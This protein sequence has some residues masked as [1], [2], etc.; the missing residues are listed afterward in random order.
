MPPAGRAA[1]AVTDDAWFHFRP[2][3]QVT[4]WDEV[5]FWRPM[6]SQ[7]FALVEPGGP[8]FFRLKAPTRAIAGFGFFAA[9]A[10][11]SVSMAWEVFGDRNGDP[12]F[13]SFRRR[14]NGYAIDS[15]ATQTA[16]RTSNSRASSLGMPCF[17]QL[18]TGS[19]GRTGKAGATTSSP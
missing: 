12:D 16:S 11:M 9:S 13:A 4:T 2:R 1:V 5:N 15:A 6:S 3:D 7:G 10:R 17:Y 18:A 19:H 14:L 8:V